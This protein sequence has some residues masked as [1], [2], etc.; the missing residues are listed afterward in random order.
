MKPVTKTALLTI[1]LL[2]CASLSNVW[3]E[4]TPA[5]IMLGAKAAA[6]SPSPVYDGKQVL[7]PICVLDLLSLNYTTSAN[8][9]EMAIIGTDGQ[10]GEVETVNING[11][12]MVPMDTVAR[13]VGA[14]TK[15]NETTHTLTLIA[16]LD[17]VEFVD[18]TLK[19]NC[20]IP[21]T[22][23]THMY[24]DKL[25]VDIASTKIASAAKEVYIGSPLISR[26]R[27]GHVDEST[28][29][30]VLDLVKKVDYRVDSRMPS[31][32]ILLFVGENLPKPTSEDQAKPQT[33]PKSNQPYNV[34]Q[35][36][37]ETVDDNQFNIVISTSS[38]G[39]ATSDYGV[40][41]PQIIAYLKRGTLCE[42]AKAIEGSHPLLKG[43]KVT[44][45]S[46]NIR[47]EI[48]PTRLM[49]YNIRVEPESI[50]INVFTPK[51]SGGKLADKF[52]VV[53]PGHGGPRDS[54]ASRVGVKEKNVNLTIAKELAAALQLEGARVLLTRSDDSAMGLPARSEVAI[55]NNADF[56]ISIHCN[57]N[58]V[59]DST[60]GIETYYH[61][62][63]P[64]PTALA[65]AVHN[66][67]CSYT[68]MCDLEARSDSTLYVP[69]L[70]VLRRLENTGIPGI[71][72]ECGYLNHSSDR[73]KLLDSGHRSKLISGIMAGFKAYIEGSPI[74]Q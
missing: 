23:T 10:S 16:H 6:L 26:A 18:N 74:Q 40:N 4:I 22:Y 53:D 65:Y 66:G 68:G 14:D 2:V 71:L 29:R 51:N 12:Q 57:A 48:N 35:I 19:I 46:K 72:L 54:G 44:Q 17:S 34:Q 61:F 42:S 55:N 21:V 1:I 70:A 58:N 9:D 33:K 32:Q 31:S 24:A 62:K 8:K 49:T 38:T 15:W 27:L 39:S 52:V 67:V 37:L 45:G 50:I 25:Y 63:E 13:L 20:S 5:R 56:F 64:S 3:A 60:S 41:P 30:V 28:A 47:L 11:T 69:G 43:M 36:R 59:T 7:A 73:S